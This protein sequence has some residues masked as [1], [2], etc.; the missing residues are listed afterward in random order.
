MPE[1]Y[2]IFCPKMP[3]FSIK[4]TPIFFPIF[5]FL[6]GGHVPPLPPPPSPTRMNTLH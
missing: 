6:G 1:V 4:I 5:F 2:M 3:E